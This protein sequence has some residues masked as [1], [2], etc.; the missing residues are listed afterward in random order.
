[1]RWQLKIFSPASP[2]PPPA[3]I[4]C[5]AIYFSMAECYGRETHRARLSVQQIFPIEQELC[6]RKQRPHSHDGWQ[7]LSVMA[8]Y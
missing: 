3:T 6:S 8:P 5:S 4:G 7:S 1:M 2:I